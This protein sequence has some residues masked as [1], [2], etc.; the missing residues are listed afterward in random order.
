ML[1]RIY[2][3][4]FH[5]KKDLE[6]HLERL[7]QARARDHR[8]LGPQLGLFTFS[9]IS[10]GSAFWLPEGHAGLQHARRSA[11]AR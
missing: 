6:Q 1:T 11:R 5:S 3:T 4:A 9:E 7:E 2:G 8:K 10:P